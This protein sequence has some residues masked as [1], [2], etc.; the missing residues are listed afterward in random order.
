MAL[1]VWAHRALKSH[2][3]RL[4][5]WAVTTQLGILTGILVGLMLI[6][7]ADSAASEAGSAGADMY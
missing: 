2:P 4:S 6:R 1:L 7:E 5:A 3:R